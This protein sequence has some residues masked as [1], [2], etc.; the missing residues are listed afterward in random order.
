MYEYRNP[1]L[2]SVDTE[3][4][5]PRPARPTWQLTLQF[6]ATVIVLP[7][8]W[9]LWLA[10]AIVLIGIAMIT[11]IF[12]Y[13]IPGYE[14]GFEKVMDATLG[15]ME[16]W[17]LWA[18]TWP[19]LR[20]EGDADFYRARVDKHL[21][22]WTKKLSAPKDPKTPEL[23]KECVVPLR[24]YRGVGG[25]YVVRTATPLGWDLQP[26][27][28]EKEIKLGWVAAAAEPSA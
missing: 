27:E 21:D 17:P 18:V 23:P 26:S 8:W 15:R 5:V 14:R 19:E 6:I 12:T 28:P 3:S 4:W 7:V 16:L 24:F 22:K 11:E 25:S 1:A 13:I 20:H 9:V 10:F 2:G